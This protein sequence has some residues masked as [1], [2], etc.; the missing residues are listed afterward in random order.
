MNESEI[1]KELKEVRDRL[2]KIETFF[3]HDGLSVMLNE[4]ARE[5][6]TTRFLQRTMLMV[7]SKGTECPMRCK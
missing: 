6:K 2:D 3:A 1:A 7:K 5:G 4:S